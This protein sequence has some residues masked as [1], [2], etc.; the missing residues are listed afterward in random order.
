MTRKKAEYYA[1]NQ[2]LSRVLLALTAGWYLLAWFSLPEAL[3]TNPFPIWLLSLLPLSFLLLSLTVPEIKRYVSDLTGIVFFTGTLHLTWLMAL[4][5]TASPLFA[6]MVGMMMITGFTIRNQILLFAFQVVMLTSIEFALLTSSAFD[7]K[8]SLL[9][10]GM[11]LPVMIGITWFRWKARQDEVVEQGTD[12]NITNTGE[13]SE[14]PTENGLRYRAYLDLVEQGLVICDDNGLIRLCNKHAAQ[15]LSSDPRHHW[16]GDTLENLVGNEIAALIGSHLHYLERNENNEVSFT[17]TQFN[18]QATLRKGIDILDRQDL[19]IIECRPMPSISSAKAGTFLAPDVWKLINSIFPFNVIT[20]SEGLIR[21]PG[22]AIMNETGYNKDELIRLS[23]DQMIHPEDLKDYRAKK[24]VVIS[25]DM[26]MN[27]EFRLLSKEDGSRYMKCFLIGLENNE[28]LHLLHDI[29]AQVITEKNLQEAASNLKAVVENT[30]DIIFSIDFNMRLMLFNSAFADEC[31]RRE[32]GRPRTGD[33]YRS[34]LTS[35]STSLWNESWQHTMRGKMSKYRESVQYNDGTIDHFEVSQ[36]PITGSSGL[37]IGV[38]VHSRKVTE[39]V[40]HE[41][42]LIKARES[43]EL[44]ARAKSEFLATMSHEIRTPLN[45]LIGMA[46]LLRNTELSKEQRDYASSIEISGEAL[47]SII[48]NVLDYSRI[49]SEKMVLEIVPFELQSCITDTISMLRYQA[50]GRGNKLG[51]SISNEVPRYVAGDK[52]RIRQ[53]LV[54]LVGNAIKFTENGNISIHAHLESITGSNVRIHFSVSDTGIGMTPEQTQKLFRAFSQADPSTYRKYGGTGLGLAISAQLTQLM[55]GQ[56]SVESKPGAGSTFHFIIE[57]SIVD[58][59]D[60]PAIS[61]LPEGGKSPEV[62]ALE[63]KKYSH[64]SILIAE[65]NV[66]NR[67]LAQAV[68]RNF[69][70]EPN[71]ADDGRMAVELWEKNRHDIIFMD[72]QMP[73]MDGLE[74]SREI[75]KRSGNKNNPVIIAMTAYA[76]EGDRVQCFEAGMNDYLT[77][78]FKPEELEQI[79]LKYGRL[80]PP[81]PSPGNSV[82]IFNM[83]D[84]IDPA[85]IDRLEVMS[86]NDRDFLKNIF[87]MYLEQSEDIVV[88]I[89]KLHGAGAL[90]EMG[91]EAHKLKGSSLNLGIKQL[92]ELCRILEIAARENNI[93]AMDIPLSQ[94]D[95]VLKKSLEAIQQLINKY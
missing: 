92:A 77:K 2:L 58:E 40:R 81:S 33:D 68:L 62:M 14:L 48:N 4:Q 16:T 15:M 25:T 54:N 8:R 88:Q 3:G 75:R 6:M 65:D 55:N 42:E 95:E 53:I 51:Y 18:L 50:E 9:M 1:G 39:R 7:T 22:A 73:E 70:F 20:D 69:G 47:L 30:D 67:K 11:I 90:I 31:V 84:W 37:I 89:K 74:A 78:P 87:K 46:T 28:C 43:A 66:I 21:Q 93:S 72:V 36:H 61:A 86:G 32:S 80:I 27:C 45:G 59:R 41:I 5:P 23:F 85:A 94:L 35:S 83:S 34:Y 63:L 29:T 12:D 10:M 19:I 82:A 49:E 17:I 71:L 26:T 13:E 24:Q 60:T 44:A 57:L 79:L 64:L 52:T 76:M 91:A 56:I 38:A